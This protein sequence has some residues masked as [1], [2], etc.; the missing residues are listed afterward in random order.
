MKN[1]LS[2]LLLTVTFL[3]SNAQIKF[4]TEI[5][6]IAENAIKEPNLYNTLIEQLNGEGELF[7]KVIGNVSGESMAS[8]D[9]ESC[10]EYFFNLKKEFLF[11]NQCIYQDILGEELFEEVNIIN[12]DLKSQGFKNEQTN[13]CPNKNDCKK[14][15]LNFNIWSNSN[16]PYIFITQISSDKNHAGFCMVKK[17]FFIANRDAVILSVRIL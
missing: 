17:D 11:T 6:L 9:N 7:K 10:F 4:E 16:Y 12:D 2:L 5:L 8:L 15:L 13:A 14:V 1:L 3:S